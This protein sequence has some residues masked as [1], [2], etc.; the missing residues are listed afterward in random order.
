MSWRRGGQTDAEGDE[1]GEEEAAQPEED[2]LNRC[3]NA[4]KRQQLGGAE[5]GP[6]GQNLDILP[7]FSGL[8]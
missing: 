1:I 8:L 5:R 2:H 7:L 4:K 6:A 3:E